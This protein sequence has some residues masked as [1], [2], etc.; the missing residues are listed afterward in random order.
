MIEST[1]LFQLKRAP[2]TEGEF[3]GYASVFGPPADIVGDIISRGAFADAIQQHKSAGTR[4]AML[5]SHNHSEPIGVDR[6]CRRCTRPA[7]DWQVDAR[8]CPRTRGTCVVTG[9]RNITC[10]SDLPWRQVVREERAGIREITKVARLA[11]ISLVAMPANTRA[12]GDQVKAR[13]ANVREFERP[14]RDAGFSS[15]EAKAAT[16]A[17]W[18][19]IARDERSPLDLVLDKIEQLQRSIEELQNVR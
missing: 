15:R 17:G 9:R 1:P 16:A 12:T 18:R 2:T 13:P 19:G 14:L 8:H 3:E 11:E 4:P 6:V 7:G 10:P 5:W